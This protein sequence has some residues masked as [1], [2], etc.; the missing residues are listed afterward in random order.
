MEE[1]SI[2]NSK[3]ELVRI[4]QMLTEA[5]RVSQML[6]SV[7]KTIQLRYS[8]FNHY[9]DQLQLFPLLV[10]CSVFEAPVCRSQTL[11]VNQDL[12]ISELE[13][14]GIIFLV[15]SS[16]NNTI[17]LPSQRR[18]SRL[19]MFK[20]LPLCNVTFSRVEG[21][22]RTYVIIIPLLWMHL[23]AAEAQHRPLLAQIPLVSLLKWSQTF[24]DKE[25]ITLG[26][27]ALRMYFLL[28][29]GH[30]GVQTING[31]RRCTLQLSELFPYARL[32]SADQNATVVLPEVINCRMQTSEN[33]IK[34]DTFIAYM[35]QMQHSAT[36]ITNCPLSSFADS[37]VFT[38]P[39]ILIQAKQHNTHKI[40]TRRCRL[41]GICETR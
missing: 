38:E 2:T 34:G 39:P 9:L 29:C 32:P 20:T 33:Q 6:Q 30:D 23:V 24:A 17:T 26:V 35:P 14:D 28:E 27:L 4:V 15:L 12:T 5:D 1:A 31:R 37:F 41:T 22:Q 11:S 25:K 18:V 21:K 36:F 16:T 10:A 8:G 7:A 40:S 3:P 13:D 19:N